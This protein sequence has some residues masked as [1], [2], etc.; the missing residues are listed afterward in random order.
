MWI[1]CTVHLSYRRRFLRSIL[2]D[3]PVAVAELV[4]CRPMTKADEEAARCVIYAGMQ[5]H[6]V[7]QNVRPIEPFPV[8]VPTWSM[9]KSTWIFRPLRS[10]Q[11]VIRSNRRCYSISLSSTH[12]DCNLKHISLLCP[13]PV[14]VGAHHVPINCKVWPADYSKRRSR[15]RHGSDSNTALKVVE[16]TSKQPKK[17]FSRKPCRYGRCH[18]SLSLK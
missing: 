12:P 1:L 3:A 11:K 14:S 8:K 15:F 16:Q 7:F 6:G 2:L 18:I 17:E 5:W 10:C 9:E 4:D 13:P